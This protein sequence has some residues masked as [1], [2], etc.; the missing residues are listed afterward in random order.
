M[1]SDFETIEPALDK[2]RLLDVVHYICAHCAPEDLGNVKLHKILYFS[3]MIHYIST[4]QALTGVEYQK[5]KFGPVARHLTW[6]LDLLAAQGAIEMRRRDYHGFTKAEYVSLSRPAARL[7]NEAT[8]IISE[9]IDF[10]CE[11]SAKEISDLSHNEAWR[12]VELGERIPYFTAF[13]LQPTFVT[14]DDVAT[15]ERELS[16][17][18][19]FAR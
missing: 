15:S 19:E 1:H 17:L 7:S 13:A 2:Q 12:S 6:A 8:Q 3:D 18:P 16:V 5:Q 9:V 4:G 11:R 14:D 10:V